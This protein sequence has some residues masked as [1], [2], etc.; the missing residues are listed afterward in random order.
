[1]P[2]FLEQ[3]SLFA[4][5]HGVKAF[6]FLVLRRTQT[7]GEFNDQGNDRRGDHRKDDGERTGLQ[8]I[9][10]EAVHEIHGGE[11]AVDRRIGEDTGEDRAERPA[12]RVDAEGVER[13]I[14]A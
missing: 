7:D 11:H 9:H 12:Q 6:A 10:D 8:L 5:V 14:I 1:V 3:V 4:V 13:I 2:L